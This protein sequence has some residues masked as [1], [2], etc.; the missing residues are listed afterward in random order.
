MTT[1]LR[2][3]K[4]ANGRIPR[5]G[6]NSELT[7]VWDCW[8]DAT[9]PESPGYFNLLYQK[10]LTDTPLVY[11]GLPRGDIDFEEDANGSGVFRFVVRYS[12]TPPDDGKL[13]WA[14]DTTG[15]TVNLKTSKAT[16]RYA[17]AGRTAPDHRGA[18]GVKRDEVEGVDI[19]IPALKLTA[20][21]RHSQAGSVVN[22]LTFD[23]YLKMLARYTGSTNNATW[24]TYAAGEMLFLGSTGEYVAGKDTEIQYHF[25]VSENATGLSIGTIAGV[26]KKGH[27][28]L[29]VSF[30]PSETGSGLA[31]LPTFCYVERVYSEKP[32]V[33]FGIGA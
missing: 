9:D 21:Y 33:D 27:E 19:V 1:F 10:I 30:E 11:I 28:Y 2:Q 13:R 12:S 26:A 24:L 20:T 23:A 17:V 7:V 22:D 25:A 18:I 8:D 4:G 16:T 32:F 31:R 29:W 15:G 14:W 5:D 6:L 3:H